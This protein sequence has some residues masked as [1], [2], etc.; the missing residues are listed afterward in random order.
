MNA[1][2]VLV[3]RIERELID[4]MVTLSGLSTTDC[5]ACRRTSSGLSE[6]KPFL[7]LKVGYVNKE[8]FQFLIT[9]RRCCCVIRA[10]KER[11][12]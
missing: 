3:S 5:E 8:K 11:L 1:K 12:K 10:L 4:S 7:G 6:F 2:N 9:E